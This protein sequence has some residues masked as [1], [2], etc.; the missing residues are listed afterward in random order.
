MP[1]VIP[2][3]RG[4]LL[5]DLF[6]SGVLFGVFAMAQKQFPVLKLRNASSIKTYFNWSTGK[7]SA[8]ALHY[9][10]QDERFS[11]RVLAHIDQCTSQSE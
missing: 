4:T 2:F 3:L 10:L 6:Y 9:L 1:Q 8:L 11:M 5:G 7:D